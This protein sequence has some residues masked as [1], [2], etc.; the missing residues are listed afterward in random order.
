MDIDD[1]DSKSYRI[2]KKSSSHRSK[3]Q[4]ISICFRIVFGMAD[5]SEYILHGVT[6][7]TFIQN[8]PKTRYPSTSKSME[9]GFSGRF[10]F[11]I[12]CAG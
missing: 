9:T 8:K 10:L 12:M 11:H 1:I 3:S 2:K 5:D 7:T 4:A 6:N